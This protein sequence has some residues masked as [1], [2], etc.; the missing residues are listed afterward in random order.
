MAAEKGNQ[1]YKLAKEA[2]GRPKA[3]ETREVPRLC[4]VE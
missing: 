3:I 1:Y 4:C 2:L